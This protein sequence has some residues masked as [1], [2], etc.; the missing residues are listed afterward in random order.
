M[1]N[2]DSVKFDI[3]VALEQQ[4]GAYPLPFIGMD[5]KRRRQSFD[6]LIKINIFPSSFM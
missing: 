5:S 3:E 1:A 6:V 2:V 4:L